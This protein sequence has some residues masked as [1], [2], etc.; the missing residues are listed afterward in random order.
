MLNQK[1]IAFIPI[2][3]WTVALLFT[4]AAVA[5]TGLVTI[6]LSGNQTFGIP[7]QQPAVIPT[8]Y[9]S[10]TPKI[11]PK[12][13]VQGI[14]QTN[15]GTQESGKAQAI[16][17]D[18]SRSGPIVDYLELCTGKTIKVY[19]NERVPYKRITGETVYSTKGDIKCY[20]NQ[21]NQLKQ[22]ANQPTITTTNKNQPTSNNPPCTVYYPALDRSETYPHMSPEDCKKEQ[23]LMKGTTNTYGET[24][25]SCNIWNAATNKNDSFFITT[26]EC[27]KKMEEQIKVNGEYYDQQKQFAAQKQQLEQAHGAACQNVVVEWQ[28]YKEQF[29][30]G[31]GKNY[32]SS[33]EAVLALESQRKSYQQ[34]MY[35]AGCSQTLY[36]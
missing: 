6:N 30:A 16:T 13:Q 10:P 32:S 27:I 5:Q 33:Y 26:S 36:L 28:S 23:E 25:R 34:Q 14:T 8:T 9:P 2:L 20:E 18:G 19:E 17:H 12:G 21:I 31:P 24:P 1:G 4:G 7:R 35:S 15:Q 22:Q 3:I 11:S 29:W